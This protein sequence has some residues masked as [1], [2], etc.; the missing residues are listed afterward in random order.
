MI[1]QTLF[2]SVSVLPTKNEGSILCPLPVN[3]S[4]EK[5][6]GEKRGENKG[7]SSPSFAFFFC[8]PLCERRSLCLRAGLGLDPNFFPFLSSSFGAASFGRRNTKLE[9]DLWIY[10][11]GKAN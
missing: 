3:Q 8:G 7:I 1:P 5:C 6:F 4:V 10:D 11:D 2:H 9:R